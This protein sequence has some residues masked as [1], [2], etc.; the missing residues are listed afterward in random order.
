MHCSREASISG[1]KYLPSSSSY[2][3]NSGLATNLRPIG[4]TKDRIMGGGVG[5]KAA[6]EHGIRA[7]TTAWFDSRGGKPNPLFTYL[8]NVPPAYECDRAIRR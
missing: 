5:R 4:Y 6:V 1:G 3:R 2:S 8:R 7:Y